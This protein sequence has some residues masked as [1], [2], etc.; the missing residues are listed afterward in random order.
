MPAGQGGFMR[1]LRYPQTDNLNCRQVAMCPGLRRPGRNMIHDLAETPALTKYR[2]GAES[3]SLKLY[4]HS[5][6]V[7][8]GLVGLGVFHDRLHCKTMKQGFLDYF[9]R[10]NAPVF[11]DPSTHSAKP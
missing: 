10:I 9:I 4:G 2:V 8:F 6:C 11:H 5:D 3:V 7:K 1:D